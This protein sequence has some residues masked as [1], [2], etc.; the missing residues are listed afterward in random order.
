MLDEAQAAA[1]S[2]GNDAIR[3]V[4]LLRIAGVQ[5]KF[6]RIDKARDLLKLI[7]EKYVIGRIDVLREIAKAESPSGLTEELAA[8]FNEAAKLVERETPVRRA[9]L[10]NVIGRK[11]AEAGLTVAR[12]TYDQAFRVVQTAMAGPVAEKSAG[13][14]ELRTVEQQRFAKL[15]GAMALDRAQAGDAAFALTIA[16]A[17]KDAPYVRAQALLAVA[18]AQA[19]AGSND[20]AGTTLDSAVLASRESLQTGPA[21][22]ERRFGEFTGLSYIKLLVDV[23][24][25]QS[26]VGLGSKAAATFGDALA[27]LP[28]VDP[29]WDQSHALSYIAANQKA[30][31]RDEEA[32]A[33]RAR[34]RRAAQAV[35]AVKQ[36]VWAFID[37]AE[38]QVKAGLN[39][40]AEET[41]DD[42][43]H[44]ADTIG[45]PWNRSVALGHVAASLA[46]AGSLPE[47]SSSFR[48]AVQVAL[49]GVGARVPEGAL[50]G[51]A[52]AQVEAGFSEDARATFV[53]W[54]EEERL[55]GDEPT[56]YRALW[57]II[58]Q[59]VARR[60]ISESDAESRRQILAAAHAIGDT[61][62]RAEALRE[63]AELEPM[64]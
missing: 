10:L 23:A 41:F 28:L 13:S 24:Q 25:A 26:A 1:G 14:T 4:E 32:A 63:L 21:R 22:P 53:Q 19:R 51:L 17:I 31:G 50:L 29:D 34:A 54:L 49:S 12:A 62:L 57:P 60:L 52:Q 64:P 7:D 55:N 16:K 37:V 30:A 20:E 36:R 43:L 27:A 59:Q 38:T 3:S 9:E 46:K 8:A 18:K 58:S 6:G 15:L 40:E 39:S 45:D 11:E 61:R 35:R 42:A 48:R 44:A 2:I 56:R 47:A 5:A 33:T